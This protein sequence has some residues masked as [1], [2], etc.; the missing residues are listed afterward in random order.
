MR[1]ELRGDAGD[2]G[3]HDSS[4]PSPVLQTVW[5]YLGLFYTLKLIIRFHW[6]KELHFSKLSKTVLKTAYQIQVSHF[7]DEKRKAH[8]GKLTFPWA[9]KRFVIDLQSQSQVWWGKAAPPLM[10]QPRVPLG[11]SPQ[12]GSPVTADGAIQPVCCPCPW[13]GEQR[14][15]SGG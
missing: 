12:W 14:W 6:P 1:W 9:H 3:T 10:C 4:K 8:G 7:A 11:V 5:L 15:P 2:R 13:A